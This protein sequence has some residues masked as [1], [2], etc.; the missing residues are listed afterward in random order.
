MSNLKSALCAYN[1]HNLSIGRN[2]LWTSDGYIRVIIEGSINDN[3]N[4]NESFVA[5]KYE[6]L[7][8]AYSNS[9]CVNRQCDDKISV[10]I[11]RT[12]EKSKFKS[13][14]IR[15]HIKGTTISDEYIQ[16]EFKKKL[17]ERKI[18]DLS[19]Y[20]VDC[21]QAFNFTPLFNIKFDLKSQEISG[22]FK[23]NY[24]N[25]SLVK[26]SGDFNLRLIQIEK[27]ITLACPLHEYLSF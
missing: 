7:Q 6:K 2:S 3:T 16:I 5:D 11:Q 19:F 17:N 18:L 24:F 13:I 20:T 26:I 23:F 21:V 4:F 10:N 25:S 14:S 9:F 15:F 8:M 1:Y 27:N 22:N 12:L